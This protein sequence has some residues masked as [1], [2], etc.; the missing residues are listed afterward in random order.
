MNWLDSLPIWGLGIAIFFLR[1]LDVSIGTIRTITVVQGRTRLSVMLG[2]FEVLIWMTAVSKVFQYAS[3]QP[4][5]LLC[6]ASGF[7]TGNAVGI[8]IERRLALGAVILRL[9]THI[10]VNEMENALRPRSMQI[11]CFPGRDGDREVTLLYVVCKRRDV[12][13]LIELARG[14][15]DGIFFAVDPIKESS[16]LLPRTLPSATGW[17]AVQKMK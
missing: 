1:I 9:V 5:I 15:D 3:T 8:L 14:H 13:D 12:P 6:Y 4:Y 7:A 10:P 16:V 17:R 2:F 11:I